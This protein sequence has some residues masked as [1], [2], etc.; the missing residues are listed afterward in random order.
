MSKYVEL[1]VKNAKE[2][3]DV[4]KQAEQYGAILASKVEAQI[5]AQEAQIIEKTIELNQAE[6]DVVK[7]QITLTKHV[8]TYLGGVKKAWEVRDI[9]AEDLQVANDNLDKLKELFKIF[10]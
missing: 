7:A 3:G 5:K 6:E 4:K 1:V 9:A 10:S 2:E 8:D